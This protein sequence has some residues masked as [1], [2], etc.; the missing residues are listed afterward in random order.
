[1]KQPF[2]VGCIII[3]ATLRPA[4]AAEHIWSG[5]SVPPTNVWS[6]PNNF[7]GSA[8][9]SGDSVTF[10]NAGSVSSLGAVDNVADAPP[11]LV[12]FNYKAQ[13]SGPSAITNYHTTRINSGVTLTLDNAS[14]SGL[15]LN[16]GDVDTALI[17]AQ[18]YCTIT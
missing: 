15:L 4:A 6:D 18:Y 7:D 1:M 13:V 17:D 8:L 10:A 12:N 2:L 5:A 9:V 14:N 16:V 11:V 3:V